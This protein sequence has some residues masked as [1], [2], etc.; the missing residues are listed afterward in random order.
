MTIFVKVYINM[1]KNVN[2]NYIKCQEKK[3]KQM[4]FWERK[5]TIS[6]KKDLSKKKSNYTSLAFMMLIYLCY[7]ICWRHL[8]R[9]KTVQ[10]GFFSSLKRT[11]FLHACTSCFELPSNILVLYV[12]EVVALQKKYLIYMH[13]KMRFTPF[14]NYYDT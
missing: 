6:N 2:L 8:M 5:S 3:K 7:L 4:F 14:I 9:S 10:H 1:I 12:Q 11:I 13:Q